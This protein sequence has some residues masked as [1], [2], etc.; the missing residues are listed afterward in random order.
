[1]PKPS[2]R[3]AL[4]RDLIAAL[5][6]SDLHVHLD[7]SLR[8]G[9]LIELARARKVKLPSTSQSG[10]LE[11]V[12]KRAYRNLPEYL[13]GFEF[14]VACLQDAESL[15]RV[16]H[17]LCLDCRAENVF[18][19]EIR[20]APQLHA[21]GDFDVVAVLR[22]VSNGIA[23]AKKEINSHPDIVAG[24]L[25]HFE[26]GIL[27]CAMRFFL[28]VFSGH[29]RAYFDALPYAPRRSIYGLASLELVRATVRAVEDEGLPV[30]GVDLAGQ[31]RGFPAKDHHE[32]YQFAHDHFL[33]K[34]VHAGEDYGPESIFQAITDCHADRIGHG[35]W[36]FSTARIQ[37]ASIK[38]KKGYVQSLVR[39]VA[40]RRI[41]L[42]VCLTSNQ[43]TIP[44]FRTD[45]RKHPFR[46]M[47]KARIS[48][49][50]CTD[51]RLV[52]RTTMTDE[53]WKA[54]ETFDLTPREVKDL[55]I[56]GFKRSFFPGSYPGKREYVRAV[57]N[58]MESL[59][60]QHGILLRPG[61]AE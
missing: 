35:T 50:L 48:V 6:K 51:N 49:T 47:R 9:T 5:P 33:G 43:Q 38:D 16:A 45:L 15:A 36:L 19:V 37:D 32:A 11:T 13:K 42:E 54:V 60:A 25:P 28:P 23:R 7:G 29:Y 56:Y 57:L 40:D 55:L 21:R 24:R 59:M 27:V 20:F 26:A 4:T 46:D 10:L 44:E 61:A 18:Y 41:T 39:Y 8:L 12:F 2:P 22:A 34:T 30:V 1:M 53:V 17:E 52:S 31:E 3:P 58:R 14:T